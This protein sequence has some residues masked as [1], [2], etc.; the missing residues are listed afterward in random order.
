MQFD[1]H[2]KFVVSHI[3]C[4]CMQ[5]F[6]KFG[7]APKDRGMADPI[8]LLPM[9]PS[10]NWSFQVKP[11][12]RNEEICQKNFDMLTSHLAMRIYQLL[13]LISWLTVFNGTFSA[14]RAISCHRSM[15][16]I[17]CRAINN[18]LNRKSHKWSSA[19]GLC[20]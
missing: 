14:Q 1:H 4:A 19:W 7:T 6:P 18:T 10:Q 12:K 3:V 5:Q 20:R 15:K 16:Y 8:M 11:Y 9:L 13:R 2:A 17:L